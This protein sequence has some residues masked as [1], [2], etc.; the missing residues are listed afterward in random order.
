MFAVSA[1]PGTAL[2]DQFAAT[3]QSPPTV[4]VQVSVAAEAHVGASAISRSADHRQ[5]RGE[6]N[7]KFMGEYLV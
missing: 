7:F 4:F 1:A 3:F 2:G 5:E 6:H